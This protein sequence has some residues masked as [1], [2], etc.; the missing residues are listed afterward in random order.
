MIMVSLLPFCRSIAAFARTRSFPLP[1]SYASRMPSFPQIMPPVGKSGPLIYFIISLIWASGL[2]IKNINP[3]MTSPKLWGAMFVAIP[4]AIP[5]EPLTN[6]LGI[7]EGRTSGSFVLPSKFGE[8][9]T[10]FLSISFSISSEMAAR[11]A[12]V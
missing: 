2:S 8:K 3:S 9:S 1:V 6:K 7:P 12:S 10:V 4:T 11:R 5:L